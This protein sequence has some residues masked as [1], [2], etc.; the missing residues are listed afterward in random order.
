MK[1][2]ALG[3]AIAAASLAAAGCSNLYWHGEAF[4]R[5]YP[6]PN[7][8]TS[9]ELAERQAIIHWKGSPKDK[10]R[11]GYLE[12]YMITLA[13]SREPHELYYIRDGTGMNTLG[14]ITENGIFFR[15]T[16]N[17]QAERMGEYPIRD[18]GI[19]LFFGFPKG[20]NLAFEDIATYESG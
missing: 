14:Y 18:V 5:Y 11:V 16:A 19:R 6:P 12:K 9:Q 1:R 10:Q 15:Y 8:T 3:I 7:K 4:S 2:T 13:G 20:D 17:G